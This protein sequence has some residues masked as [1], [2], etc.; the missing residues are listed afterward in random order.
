[1]S[2]INKFCE[3]KSCSIAYCVLLGGVISS[4]LDQRSGLA[5]CVTKGSMFQ[6]A[7]KERWRGH[8][9]IPEP[10]VS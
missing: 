9:K 2:V 5:V 7:G 6:E 10:H 8:P 1:M 4:N 3:G